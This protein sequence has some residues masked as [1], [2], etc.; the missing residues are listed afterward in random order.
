MV[1]SKNFVALYI[2]RK[3]TNFLF[4]TLFQLILEKSLKRNTRS[5][6]RKLLFVKFAPK[7]S[8]INDTCKK[9]I[10]I[11]FSCNLIAVWLLQ[12]LK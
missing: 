2:L 5:Q 9:L 8:M 11:D 12:R 10:N 3:R 1:L 4:I 6:N 7:L